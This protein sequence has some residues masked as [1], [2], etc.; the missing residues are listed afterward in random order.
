MMVIEAF[1]NALFERIE[2]EYDM[3][4]FAEYEVDKAKGNIK[5]YCHE[6]IWEEFGL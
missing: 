5:T 3:K 6:E 1:K 2:D 4:V